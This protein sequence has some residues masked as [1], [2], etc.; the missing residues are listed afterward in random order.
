MARS[1]EHPSADDPKV[2]IASSGDEVC[3]LRRDGK[4]ACAGPATRCAADAPKP[5]KLAPKPK[6][7]A[8][9]RPAKKTATKTTA[10]TKA[11][12]KTAAKTKAGAAAAKPAGGPALAIEVLRLPPAQHLAFDVGLCVVTK[13]GRLQCLANND[14]CRV[15]T[16]WPGLTIVDYVTGNCARLTNGEARCWSVDTKSR[17]VT[18]VAGVGGAIS[19]AASSS[20]ACAVLGDRSLVCWGSNRFGALGRGNADEKTYREASPVTF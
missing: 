9:K 16:A 7:T 5:A 20:H 10:K 17:L 4:V 8:A 12:A 13:T 6:K 14:G 18:E 3:G 11:T 19:V 2:E 1:I 15:D